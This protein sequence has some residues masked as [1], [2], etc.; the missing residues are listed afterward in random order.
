MAK[1]WWRWIPRLMVGGGAA[2]ALAGCGPQYV[3]LHPAGPVAQQELNLMTLAGVAMAIVIAF[4]FVLFF[5]A[6]VRFRERPGNRNPYLPD[7]A[8]NRRLEVLWFIIP[9]LILAIIAVPT[10][11]ETFALAAPPKH[12][13][14]VV[15]DVTSLSWKWLF[16]YPDQHVATVN[17]LVIPTGKPVLFE[18]WAHSAMNT[19]WI[20][21]LGGMEYTMP[22]QVLPLWLEASRPGTYWGHSG[23]FSGLEFE[24]MFFSVHA[25]SP[26]AF[27]R[28]VSQV[29]HTAP[30]LTVADYRGLLRFGTV[31]TESF[32]GY[33]AG[34]FPVKTSGFTLTGSLLM[35][36]GDALGGS[37]RMRAAH[38]TTAMTGMKGGR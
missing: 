7:W 34:T 31:G 8:E 6:L 37:A 18:L 28:W 9:A 20:P 3:L 25:V 12:R 35:P 27:A 32:S 15:I 19:F 10:V 5:V 36:M 21:Q 24:R 2:A 29:H 14:P 4:V 13:D 16:E 11:Q 1:R 17:Y 22:N 26:S 23:N 30:L 33:P 38:G